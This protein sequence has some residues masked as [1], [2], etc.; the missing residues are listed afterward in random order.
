MVVDWKGSFKRA[1]E[2]KQKKNNM[3]KRFGVELNPVSGKHGVLQFQT[4]AVL[5]GVLLG[6]STR[7]F[8][9]AVLL[10]L[11]QR[12]TLNVNWQAKQSQPHNQPVERMLMDG[13]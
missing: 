12:T 13:C 10:G 8:Y 2:K 4:L 1:R 7:R 5:P 6:G 3:L 9:S 11:L